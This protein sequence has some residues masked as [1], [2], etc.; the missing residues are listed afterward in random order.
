MMTKRKT[1]AKVCPKCKEPRT[2]QGKKCL[3]CGHVLVREK[4]K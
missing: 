2:R 4:R 1:K 3:F